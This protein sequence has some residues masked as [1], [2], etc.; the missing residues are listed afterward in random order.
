MTSMPRLRLTFA[1]LLALPAAAALG[2]WLIGRTLTDSLPLTQYLFW[3]PAVL[4]MPAA[5]LLGTA[6]WAAHRVGRPRRALRSRAERRCG[7]ALA[8]LAILCVAC[9]TWQSLVSWRLYRAILPPPPLDQPHALSVFHW[10]MSA[11]SPSSWEAN[12]ARLPND[13]PPDLFL[14]TNVHQGTRFRE[15]R[16]RT[17]MNTAQWRHLAVASRFPVLRSA[18]ASLG[19]PRPED[20]PTNGGDGEEE[21]APSPDPRS[22]GW[23]DPGQILVAEIDTTEVLGRPIVTWI[24]DLPSDPSIPRRDV[25]ALVLD[26]LSELDHQWEA[27][28]K[29]G[30]DGMPDPDLV[31]G[32]F[33]MTRGSAALRRITGG[34][35]HAYDQA[36]WGFVATY[37]A[38][39]PLW[40]I[41]HIFVRPPL[42]AARYNVTDL[43][44][45]PHLAQRAII[46]PG[47]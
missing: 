28:N 9:V 7:R 42:R 3:V 38:S 43:G 12:L 46:V 10:N 25:A 47:R 41:D 2:V 37:P 40:H 17:G 24:I 29:G 36:G 1:L 6:A 16:D 39:R 30:F 23:Y 18:G 13:P 5:A 27:S 8:A 22:P 45:S 26:R 35:P 11:Q 31:A 21:N 34:L 20:Y 4:L 44:G 19:L 32:D 14:L 33:N 15:L